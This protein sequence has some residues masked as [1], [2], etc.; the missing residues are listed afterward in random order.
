MDRLIEREGDDYLE[1][2]G[3][4]AMV[5]DGLMELPEESIVSDAVD[6]AS[7][8]S[9]ETVRR[10]GDV[11]GYLSEAE[12]KSLHRETNRIGIRCKALGVEESFSL[13]TI[14]GWE[15]GSCRAG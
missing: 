10:T 8:H 2:E 4:R 3:V 14:I 7:N 13:L 9:E 15:G 12:M 1:R 5:A 11:I 6:W